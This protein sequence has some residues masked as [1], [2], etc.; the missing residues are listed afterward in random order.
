MTLGQH[1]LWRMLT[2][3]RRLS[4][5]SLPLVLYL[6]RE[7]KLTQ[8]GSRVSSDEMFDMDSLPDVDTDDEEDQNEFSLGKELSISELV[9]N[10][11][12]PDLKE[13]T[14]IS[15]SSGYHSDPD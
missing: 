13:T 1:S 7:L 11:S 15:F 4:Q 14:R 6:W 8:S 9:D 5:L 3:R 12:S 2:R 10:M